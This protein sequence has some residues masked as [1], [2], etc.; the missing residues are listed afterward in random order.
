M[1]VPE[2]M[3]IEATLDYLVTLSR[4]A[5]ARKVIEVEQQYCMAGFGPQTTPCIPGLSRCTP[6]LSLRCK[7]EQRTPD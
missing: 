3:G 4:L 5:D 2:E 7:A 1:Q 6:L